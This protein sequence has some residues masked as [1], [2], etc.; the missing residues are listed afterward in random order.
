MAE[1]PNRQASAREFSLDRTLSR[2]SIVAIA[3]HWLIALLI[4]ANIVL[5]WTFQNMPKGLTAFQLIQLHKSLGITVLL[6]SV[7]RLGW[8]LANPPP[9]APPMPRWQHLASQVAHWA[10]YAIMIGMPLSGWVMVS[11]SKLGLPTLLYGVIPW[12][13]IPFIHDLPPTAKK[14]WDDGADNVHSAL[15]W[16]AYVLIPLHVAAALKHQFY[17]RDDLL[18][19]MVPFLGAAKPKAAPHAP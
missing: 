4:L 2:Y 3:L 11:A 17:D 5:A 15:A 9:A 14:A 18:A 13:H 1:G 16:V 8:R 12:P 7:V 19:R 6:L 10:F